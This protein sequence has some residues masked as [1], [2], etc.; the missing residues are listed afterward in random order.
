MPGLPH[1]QIPPTD[2]QDT[3]SNRKGRL[4]FKHEAK[5]FHVNSSLVPVCDEP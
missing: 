5:S 2:Y 3:S 1:Q 4:T